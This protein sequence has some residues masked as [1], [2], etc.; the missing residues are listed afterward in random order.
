VSDVAPNSIQTSAAITLAGVD[1]AV[2][3][4]VTGGEYSINGGAFTAAAGTVSKGQSVIL[5]GTAG[6][7]TDTTTQVTLSISNASASF[8]INTV[9]D[10]SAPTAQIYFPPPVSMTEDNRILVRGTAS[11]DYHSV[12][13][14][15]VNG[16]AATTTDGYKN[17][18]AEVPLE[19]GTLPPITLKNKVNT[20]KVIAE[21]SLGNITKTE[22]APKV[23]VTQGNRKQAFPSENVVFDSP[24]TLLLDKLN[25]RS[26]LLVADYYGYQIVA[27]DL[28]TGERSLFVDLPGGE[29]VESMMIDTASEAIFAKGYG[30]LTS[31]NLTDGSLKR[32]VENDK[33]WKEYI[34]LDT[35]SSSL[36]LVGVN[37]GEGS[38]FSFD[39]VSLKLTNISSAN[40]NTPDAVNPLDKP[41][42]IVFDKER[43]RYLVAVGF[44]NSDVLA[45]GIYA[46]DATTGKRSVF[47]NNQVGSGYLFE[48][49]SNNVTSLLIDAAA[50]YVIAGELLDGRFI[51]V[52]LVTGDRT[53][54][55]D[56]GSSA[57]IN[58][59]RSLGGMQLVKPNNYLLC[60][61]YD[62]KGIYAVDMVTGER[63][64]FSKSAHEEY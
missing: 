25:G 8:T 14:V 3:I 55:S 19:D 44:N 39:P 46:V 60:S 57:A 52:D 11:D 35:S 16:V 51:K 43:N 30:R 18:Q 9:K 23:V 42:D 10:T 53:L 59:F 36:P 2:P 41:I 37:F 49:P 13:S 34:F 40:A 63:V 20:L 15:M 29:S 38:V 54:F 7:D 24:A 32:L 4:S 62:K 56:S 64:I 17:W 50:G 31:F 5:R 47:S 6:S 33:W 22:E 1:A 21:D 26:R 27:I 12:K 48:T 61:E 28:A 58:P 45:H